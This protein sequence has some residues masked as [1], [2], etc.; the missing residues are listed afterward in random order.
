MSNDKSSSGETPQTEI[1]KVLLDRIKVNTNSSER[2]ISITLFTIA[3]IAMSLLAAATKTDSIPI[4]YGILGG[5]I[6]SAPFL[7]FIVRTYLSDRNSL[8]FLA[9]FK[10][11]EASKNKDD[12]LRYGMEYSIKNSLFSTEFKINFKN[13]QLD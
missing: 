10:A 7:F 6:Y 11:L 12:D 8:R 3:L 2:M 1:E 5:I 13:N 9:F 4:Y